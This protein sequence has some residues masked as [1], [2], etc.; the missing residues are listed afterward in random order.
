[1]QQPEIP[2]MPPATNWQNEKKC[3]KNKSVRDALGALDWTNELKDWPLDSLKACLS[4]GLASQLL[5]KHNAETIFLIRCIKKT[6]SHIIALC[7]PA[8]LMDPS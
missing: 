6:I 1:M 4:K 5:A 2:Q 3:M 7:F 8:S